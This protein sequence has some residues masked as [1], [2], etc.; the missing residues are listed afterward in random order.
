PYYQ[1]F[2][3][4]DL[5]DG[6]LDFST[7]YQYHQEE[8]EMAVSL[9]EMAASLRSLRLKKEREKEDFLTIP[10]LSIQD[11]EVDLTRKTLRIG[12]FATEKGRLSVQ[13]LK[14]GEIDLQKLLPPPSP[15]EEKAPSIKE[16]QDD[17]NWIVSLGQARIDQYTLKMTDST[18]AQPTSVMVE[19]VAVRAENIS[20]AKNKLGKIALSLLLDQKTSVSTQAAAG[21]EPLRAEGSLEVRQLSLR[22][23]APYY[24]DKILFDI[25]SGDVDLSARYQFAKGEK[26]T[27]TKATGVSASVKA[28]QL[29]KRGEAEEFLSIPALS[30]RNT[31][32]DLT[33]NEIGIGEFATENGSVL[34]RR[35]KNGEINLLSLLPPAG[36]KVEKPEEKQEP[37]AGNPWVVKVGRLAIDQYRLK[38]DDQVPSEAVQILLNEIGVKGEN[39]STAKGEKGRL[40][41]ALRLD[42]KGKVTVGGGVGIDPLSADL[43][44]GVQEVDIRPVQPYFTDRVKIIVRDG[45]LSA[46][47]NLAL[48]TGEGKGLRVAYK[49]NSNLNQFASIDKLKAEDFLKWESLSLTG[50]DAGYNPFYLRLDGAALSNF[51]ARLLIYPD[52]TLNL[53]NILTEQKKEDGKPAAP[54]A[55]KPAPDQETGAKESAPPGDISIQ[56]VTLQGGHIDFSDNYIQPNYSANFME[57]GG[58]VTGLSSEEGKTADVELRGMLGQI[59][60]LEI[61]GK[62]NPLSKDLLVDLSVKFKDIDLSPMTPYSGKYVGYKIQKGKLFM[63]LKYQ[64]VKRKLDS[65]NKIFFDQFT[66]G[67]KVESPQATKLP[68]RLAISLLKDRKGEIHLDIPV[69]GSLDDPKFS[70]FGIILQVL[71]NLIAKA[72]TSP[73]ALIGAIMGGGQQ[74]DNLEFESGSAAIAGAGEAKI[75]TLLKAL[76][77]RPGVNLEIEGH[78]D[79]EKDR[80]GLKQLFFQRKL[81]AQK[82]KELV[83]KGQPSVP[84]DE[85]KI[86]PAEYPGYLKLAYKEEKFP[87]PKNFIGMAKDLPNPEMEKLMLTHIAINESDLRTLA[88]QRSVR[89]RETLVKN[90]IEGERL[91]IIE[92]KSLPPEKKDKVK[93]S[94][95]DFRLK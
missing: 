37:Q 5:A 64:I 35:L 44:V 81:K 18:P 1:E 2:I 70:V 88:S 24:Q 61:V 7:G 27:V 11:T 43:E 93:D 82:L 73:F 53:Q 32:I 92:P 56:R 23:Y 42:Q 33:K 29:K 26:E 57:L 62:V 91:F 58:R 95:V 71:G 6:W 34:V 76:K 17:K 36:R 87:K 68:V 77:D 14:S 48:N 94:R 69:T 59:A 51:Y 55:K 90:G 46:S 30:I 31:G 89:V 20:T 9:K 4:F 10:A 45:N 38:W 74:L 72:A 67:D 84:V 40:S 80:E 41:L 60:P 54:P 79:M 75:N 19:K 78:V 47:G 86:E 85:L 66:L 8:K 65:Q 13:R 49:G 83:K 28:L 12:N 3:L 39:I 63:D 50:I 15:K 21:I 25:E 22:Q 52:G 16:A